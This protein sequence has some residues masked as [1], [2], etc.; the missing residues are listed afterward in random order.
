MWFCPCCGNL[1][2]IEISHAG[3]TT[4]FRC[5]TSPF[6]KPITEKVSKKMKLTPKKV[7]DVLG[8]EDAMKNVDK[9]KETC[10]EC[11]HEWAF[12]RMQQTRSADEA[13]TRFYTCEKCSHIWSDAS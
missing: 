4:H 2:H 13:A 10:P 8:G 12:F 5:L 1:I 6:H 7:D 3:G 9:T 11:A